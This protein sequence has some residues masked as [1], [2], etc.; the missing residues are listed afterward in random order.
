MA[1]R[2]NGAED[3][4]SSSG[5][6][7]PGFQERRKETRYEPI[8]GRAFLGWWDAATY[9]TVA[10]RVRNLS[11]SGAALLVEDNPPGPD[12]VWLCPIAPARPDW[13]AADVLGVEGDEESGWVVRVAFARSFPYETFRALI[14]DSPAGQRSSACRPPSTLASSRSHPNHTAKASNS[15]PK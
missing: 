13:F 12:P 10:V 8:E 6:D 2:V 1:S 3:R 7:G 9:R 15:P 4:P 14:M 11:P 5:E